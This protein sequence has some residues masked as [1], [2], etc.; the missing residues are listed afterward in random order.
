MNRFR[1]YDPFAWLYAHHWGEPFHDAVLPALENAVLKQLP[2]HAAVLDLCC[3]DGRLAATLER[4]GFAVTG[5]DGSAEMLTFARERCRKTRFLLA[6]ARNFQLPPQFDAVLST[7]DSLNHIMQYSELARVFANVFACLK[8]GG[9][10]V[11]DLNREE[12]YRDFWGR[13]ASTVTHDVVSVARGYYVPSKRLATCDIT[14]MRLQGRQWHRTDFRMTQRLHPVE[15]VVR[16]LQRAG[17]SA[18]VND[19]VHLGMRGDMAFGR[20]IFIARKPQ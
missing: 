4:R 12:A 19:A 13:E 20:N 14:L 10:F 3:G 5:L 18:E 17:F 16:A 2:P 15:S 7:F 6:D 8:P 11:F 1:D 9:V